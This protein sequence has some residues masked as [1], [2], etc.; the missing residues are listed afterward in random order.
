[1]W[2]KKDGY[3][4]PNL[5]LDGEANGQEYYSPKLGEARAWHSMQ[6]LGSEGEQEQRLLL[7]TIQIPLLH[8]LGH[9]VVWPP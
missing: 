9:D 5:G 2:E 6:N 3:S 8:T 4:L 1:M 7:F